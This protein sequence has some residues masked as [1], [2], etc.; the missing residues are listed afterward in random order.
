MVGLAA[1]ADRYSTAAGTTTG[2]AMGTAAGRFTLASGEANWPTN[3]FWVRN[4]TRSAARYV[5]FR[6]GREFSC[7]EGTVAYR[8]LNANQTWAVGDSIEVMSDIDIGV[9]YPNATTGVFANPAT[10]YT[11][12]AGVT[13]FAADTE[14]RAVQLDDLAPGKIVVLWIRETI[15][16]DH[17]SRNDING[18]LR[19]AWS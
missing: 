14:A 3:S 2:A 5:K 1:Y 8:G 6:S 15:V 13:F 19:L 4:N 12:P 18:N 10:V 9:E 17:R 16:A 7:A 11:A